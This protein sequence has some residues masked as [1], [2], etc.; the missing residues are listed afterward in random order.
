MLK[1]YGC[2]E[3]KK[4]VLESDPYILLNLIFGTR[5]DGNKKTIYWRTGDLKKNLLEV[6]I[7]KDNGELYSITLVCCERNIING[8][9]KVDI[10]ILKEEEGC[11]EFELVQGENE[12][13]LQVLDELHEFKIFLDKKAINILYTDDPIDFSLKNECVDFFMNE[14]REWV[15]I[16]IHNVSDKILDSFRR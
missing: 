6:G 14:K 5:K 8:T 7:G 9:D 10:N 1:I 15:G 16:R 2:T 13:V 12:Q 4:P 3:I 11:P